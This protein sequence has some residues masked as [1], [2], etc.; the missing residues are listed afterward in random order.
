MKT[1]SLYF[2][3]LCLF[4]FL[5]GCDGNNI[6]ESNTELAK[7]NVDLQYGFDNY[8]VLIRFNDE[9]YFS[10]DLT[11]LVP[12][13]GPLATFVTYLEPGEYNCE[14]FWQEN[15]GQAGQPYFLDSTKITI[16]DLEEYYLGIRA[17]NDTISA[18]LRDTPFG[19]I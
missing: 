15:S 11:G 1:F 5:L 8:F 14:V 13:S 10:A 18:E 9:K 7:I 19:Y 4:F 6:T 17:N 2:T 12:L 16:G 3:T